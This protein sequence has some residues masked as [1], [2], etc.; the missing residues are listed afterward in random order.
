MSLTAVLLA[1]CFGL[2]F[3]QGDRSVELDLETAGPQHSLGNWLLGALADEGMTT[4][5]PRADRRERREERPAAL[6]TW[7]Q[8][9]R[10]PGD[11]RRL[12]AQVREGG[13][14][15]Y[16]VGAGEADLR[17]ARRIWGPLD[18]NI[19]L[20]DGGASQARWI[21][22]PLTGGSG[23]FGA[24]NA[25]SGISAPGGSPLIRAGGVSVA[26]AF[27]WGPLGRAVIIDQ[28]AVFSQMHEASPR[29]EIRDFLVR[30][31]AW[32]S[33]LDAD[34]PP[35]PAEPRRP[36]PVEEL[37][38]APQVGAPA[39][40]RTLVMLPEEGD[41]WAQFRP[42]VISELERKGLNVRVPRLREDEPVFTPE[43]LDR[44][45]LVVL[46]SDREE[47]HWGEAFAL[48][49]YFE[50]GGR[51]LCIPH[52]RRHTQTRMIALNDLLSPLRLSVS[53]GRHGGP[54]K[55]EEHPITDG[56]SFPEGLRDSSGSQ[57]TGPLTSPLVT[58]LGRTAAAA[59]QDGEGRIVI[60]DGDILRLKEGRGEPQRDINRLL[61]RSLDWLL[62]EL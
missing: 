31:T 46:G 34:A 12:R 53:L 33:G 57:I 22:H 7:S 11:A 58:V 39:F 42:L 60:I 4:H 13:G 45:G 23:S 9:D 41:E 56:L 36:P 29:P 47:V 15:V 24:V 55:L 5:W 20:H 16:V 18:V 48:A 37:T 49:R 30:A 6:V 10:A 61:R 17:Q 8:P 32:A 19:Q 27:D 26:M 54:L 28:S 43:R 38:G 21:E 52:A 14:M 35:P 1:L 3:A 62:G 59:W 51:I 40:D 50:Q 44:V 2:A 25:G